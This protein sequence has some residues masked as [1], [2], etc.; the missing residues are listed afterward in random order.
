MESSSLD[1]PSHPQDGDDASVQSQLAQYDGMVSSFPQPHLVL[2]HSVRLHF[3][4]LISLSF[5]CLTDLALQ[6]KGST[7]YEVTPAALG[8]LRGVGY[9]I[10]S[11]QQCLGD[12]WTSAYTYVG[13]PQ[14][15]DASWVC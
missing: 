7:A 14:A 9:R 3:A 11:M 4:S 6:V 5:T 10:V 8:K 12:D 2:Q 13:E 1:F 15:R